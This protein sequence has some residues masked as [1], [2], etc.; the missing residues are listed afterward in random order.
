M[1]TDLPALG[2][3]ILRVFT[4][5]AI[6]THGI[7]KLL[8][9]KGTLKW[10]QHEKFPLPVLSTIGVTLAET[11]GALLLILGVYT[12]YAGAV[13]AF[14]MLVAILFHIKKHDTWKQME[15]AALYFVIFLVI[16]IAGPGAWTLL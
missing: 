13:L 7:P 14:S 6:L 8:D 15:D 1:T 4:G 5:A 10:I 11:F 2:L 12:I 9:F 16:S 3:F